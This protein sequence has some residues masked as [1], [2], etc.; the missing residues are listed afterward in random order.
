MS[1]TALL[2][3]DVQVGMFDQKMISEMHQP[4]DLLAAV[5]R[6]IGAARAASIPVIFI[7]HCAPAGQ[8]LAE[9]TETWKIHPS[10]APEPFDSVVLK[11][12]SSAFVETDLRDLLERRGIDTVITCGL[13]S[14]HCVS[15]TSLS[16]LE[17]G[18]SVVV[19]RDAHSTFSTDDDDASEIIERQNAQLMDLG[20][21]VLAT[22]A[23]A[24]L[25]ARG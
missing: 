22:S 3:I 17:L 15:N 18:L 25:F 13:Q 4:E 6:L 9:G 5:S 19:A 20:A 14:E 24:E 23:I 10:I 7:Q 1:G 16:A 21:R 8:L 2:V 11:R 12:E